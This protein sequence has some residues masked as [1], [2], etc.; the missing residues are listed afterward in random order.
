MFIKSGL[1]E[2]DENDLDFAI[3]ESENDF[4]NEEIDGLI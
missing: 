1:G 2:V 4:E 3:E